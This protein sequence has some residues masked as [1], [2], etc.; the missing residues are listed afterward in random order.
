MWNHTPVTKPL[1]IPSFTAKKKPQNWIVECH[2]LLSSLPKP[3]CHCR[4]TRDHQ[5]Y[6][7]APT[8]GTLNPCGAVCSCF[9]HCTI[10]HART[11]KNTFAY[12]MYEWTYRPWDMGHF[13]CGHV[14]LYPYR[15]HG[16]KQGPDV[17]LLPVVLGPRGQ[18]SVVLLLRR[19]QI[20]LILQRRFIHV[21]R[22]RTHTHTH[23]DIHRDTNARGDNANTN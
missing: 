22:A 10:T 11:C 21:L 19:V 8:L 18:H 1:R 20:V 14:F 23:M 17:S 16:R 13:E 5:D 2:P 12:A 7:H 4:T 9:T 15:M 6:E 3:S